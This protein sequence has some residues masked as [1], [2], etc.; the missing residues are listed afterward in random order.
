LNNQ[1]KKLSLVLA[2]TDMVTFLFITAAIVFIILGIAIY[3]RNRPTTD[4]S[5]RVLPPHPDARSLFSDAASTTDEETKH[6]GMAAK[7]LAQS[8][9]HRAQNGDRSALADAH[10]T[11]NPD[12][13]NRTLATLVATADIDSKLFALMSFVSRNELPV[14]EALARA[15]LVS[16]QRSPNRN[17]TAKALHFAALSDDAR[18]YGEAIE[19]ALRLWREEKLKDISPTELRTLFDGEFWVLSSRTRSSGAGFVVKQ[20][21][22]NARRELEAATRADK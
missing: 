21:L 17:G 1:P 6:S 16:W 5:E 15:V 20:T 14:N 4:H 2:A 10:D 8:L 3:F 7:E 18:L 9:I 19:N 11:A 13:Y 12:L 22:A